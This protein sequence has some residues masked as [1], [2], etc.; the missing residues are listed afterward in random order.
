MEVVVGH[1]LLKE[2]SS[3]NTIGVINANYI[4]LICG[5]IRSNIWI[6]RSNI[7][8]YIYIYIYI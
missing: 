2:N 4:Y 5:K 8:V 1:R 7:G 3:H 6:T